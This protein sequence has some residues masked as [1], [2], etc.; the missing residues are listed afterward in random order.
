MIILKF[1]VVILL[2]TS[3]NSP[4]LNGHYH[5]EWG[6]STSFQTWNFKKNRIRINDSLCSDQKQVCYGMP[7]KFKGDSIYV[8]WVD[9]ILEAK[10]Y[11]D[12]NGIIYLEDGTEKPLKLIP[13]NDCINSADYLN[14]KVSNLESSFDL[15]SL[16]YNTHGKSAFPK[17]SENELIIGK[18][19]GAPYYI[20]N[21][22]LLK[23]SDNSFNVP[24]AK[25]SNDIWIYID[26]KVQLKE[27]LIIFKELYDKNYKIYFSSKDEKENNEQVIVFKKSITKIDKKNNTTIINTCEYCEKHPTQKID[28]IINFKVF[29]KDSCI[30]NNKITDYFQLRNNIVRFL[31]QNRS[32]R[33]NTEIQLEINSNMLFEDYL[34]LLGDIEFVNTELLGTYYR[35]TIDTDFKYISNKQNSRNR[36]NLELEFPLRLKEIIKPF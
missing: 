15:V 32:T 5:L 4:N 27:V 24:K 6:N 12:N 29:G 10:Y 9:F 3:C 34:Y 13:K 7:I 19:N 2:I 21:N 23:F 17:N 22:Q 33:L 28:S 35:D 31:K 1:I 8:P 26:N 11:I 14:R 25:S 16:Y 18:K 20:L 30:V 36:E